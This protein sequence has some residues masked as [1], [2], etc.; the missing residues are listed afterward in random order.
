MSTQKIALFTPANEVGRR[1][2]EEA[3]KR[4]HSVTAIVTNEAEFKLKHP[5]LTVVKGN[6]T[7]KEDVTKHARGHDIVLSAYEPSMKNPQEHVNVT[8]N[9]I[10]GAKEAG[11]QHLVV[12][13]HPFEQRMESTEQFYNS[14]K[15]LIRA[16]EEA[17]RLF[18]K[19]KN[20]TWGYAHS[21]APEAGKQQGEYRISNEI[22]LSHPQ[23]QQRVPLKDYTASLLDEAEKGMLETHES[24]Y[25]NDGIE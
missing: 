15:P 10:E 8:R 19:E 24:S 5:N 22:F 4:G 21:I 20:L 18:Q 7:R 23:G 17:L 14:F 12:A 13:S 3:L 6:V 9:I 25:E 2:A 16:Q 1:L 11:V